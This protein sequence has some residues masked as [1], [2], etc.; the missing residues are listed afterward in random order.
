MSDDA[1]PRQRYRVATQ[2]R[3]G[4]DDAVMHDVVLS[5]HETG[6]I[7]WSNTFSDENQARA[8]VEELESDLDALGLDE[9]RRKYGVTAQA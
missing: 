2:T 1:S 8:Y 4:Y 3:T 5:V 9:F 7:V 6:R